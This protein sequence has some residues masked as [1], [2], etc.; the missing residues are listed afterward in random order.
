MTRRTLLPP[1]AGTLLDD[2]LEVR[3]A[4]SQS[5]TSLWLLSVA[6]HD[7]SRGWRRCQPRLKDWRLVA[8]EPGLMVRANAVMNADD[9]RA[10]EERHVWGPYAAPQTLTITGMDG[11]G[12][13]TLESN[14]K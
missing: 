5:F 8:D 12:G 1:I 6:E 11:H 2:K 13:A 4:P 14:F 7:A 9:F 10:M 3:M